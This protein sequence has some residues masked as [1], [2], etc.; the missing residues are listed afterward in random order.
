VSP[1]RPGADPGPERPDD[2]AEDLTG[3][4]REA[5]PDFTPPAADGGADESAAP[6]AEGTEDSASS[7][8]P[9]DVGDVTGSRPV[10]PPRTPEG[11]HRIGRITAFLGMV[12]VLGMAV[13]FSIGALTTHRSAP[14]R[15]DR[16]ETVAPSEKPFPTPTSTTPQRHRGPG[17][18]FTAPAGWARTAEEELRIVD[19]HRNQIAVRILA[20][21]DPRTRCRNEL[22]AIGIWSSARY[23]ELPDRE[24]GGRVAPGGEMVGANTFRMRCV[25][26]HSAVYLIHLHAA[27]GLRRQALPA[28]TAILDSWEWTD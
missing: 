12:L 25:R 8:D 6:P 10:S 14:R 7:A 15:A 24:I 23:S 3:L 16:S 26:A 19:R 17:F 21:D 18:A 4:G 9:A 1:D 27:P 11:R 22:K 5:G 28:F 20:D 2:P 13:L